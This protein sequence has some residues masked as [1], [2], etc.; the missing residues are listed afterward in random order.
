MLQGFGLGLVNTFEEEVSKEEE[1]GDVRDER[2]LDA[3]H[4][5]RTVSP[6]DYK[7]LN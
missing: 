6:F 1:E 4:R 7:N 2:P 5:S 3:V